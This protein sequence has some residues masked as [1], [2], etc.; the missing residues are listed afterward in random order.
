MLR[1]V[2]SASSE[3]IKFIILY[4][5]QSL[6]SSIVHHLFPLRNDTTN[7]ARAIQLAFV[8]FDLSC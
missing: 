3:I 4:A 1:M 7:L 2:A 8:Q 6:I 5:E